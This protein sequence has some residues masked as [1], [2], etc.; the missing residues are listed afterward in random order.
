MLEWVHDLEISSF[1][2]VFFCLKYVQNIFIHI[3]NY[4]F[5]LGSGN[6]IKGRQLWC[7]AGSRRW[8]VTG[9]KPVLH[10][11]ISLVCWCANNPVLK[12]KVLFEGRRL[13]P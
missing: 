3:L 12:W 5:R 6:Y 4:Y 9:L 1:F 2:V 10:L 11:E 7:L 13:D 8:K